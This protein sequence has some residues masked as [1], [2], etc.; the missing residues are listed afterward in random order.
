MK[1]S[2]AYEAG[3]QPKDRVIAIDGEDMTGI[4]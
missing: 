2:P 4:L 3:L 1:G